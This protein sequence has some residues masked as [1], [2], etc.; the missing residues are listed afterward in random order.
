MRTMYDACNPIRPPAD[1]SMVAGYVSGGCEW[2]PAAW[3]LWAKALRVRIATGANVDDGVVL[4]VERGDA[5]PADA[6]GWC[7]RA[8]LRGVTPTVYTSASNV[9]AVLAACKVHDVPAP[10]IWVAQWD[11]VAT[12]PAGCIA[13][14]YRNDVAAGYDVSA[15]ADYWPGVDPAPPTPPEDDDVTDEQAQMLADIHAAIFEPTAVG[16]VTGYPAY[17]P[18][19]NIDII[20][21]KVSPYNAG[22]PPADSTAPAAAEAAPVT[23][24]DGGQS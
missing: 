22:Y 18:G 6:P 15:V 1:A 11:G 8:Q 2:S 7:A 19:N 12:V 3:Q 9:A 17:A 23:A 5:T 21:R 14:Q 20:R 13:K 16:G 10:L 24:I 4:D